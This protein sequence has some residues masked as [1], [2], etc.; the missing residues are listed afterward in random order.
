MMLSHELD[1]VFVAR[2][3][4]AGNRQSRRATASKGETEDLASGG[5]LFQRVEIGGNICAAVKNRN[6]SD[7]RFCDIAERVCRQFVDQPNRV[8]SGDPRQGSLVIRKLGRR[9]R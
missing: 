3:L 6:K 8:A 4:S 2:Q 9:D 5:K 1:N 7:I